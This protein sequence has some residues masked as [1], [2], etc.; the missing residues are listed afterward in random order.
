VI[1]GTHSTQKLVGLS[2]ASKLAVG[3]RRVVPVVAKV[4][5]DEHVVGRVRRR[6]QVL[7]EHVQT[8]D[9]RVAQRGVVDDRVEVDEWVG[10]IPYRNRIIFRIDSNP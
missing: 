2:E 7:G 6:R 10:P 4:G 8:N 5:G 1:I 9:V 3:A